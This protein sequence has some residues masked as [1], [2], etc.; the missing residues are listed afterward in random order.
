MRTKR[1]TPTPTNMAFAGENTCHIYM[2]VQI[3]S[4]S[5]LEAYQANTLSKGLREGIEDVHSRTKPH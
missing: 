3:S 5:R 4:S 1:R 2:R